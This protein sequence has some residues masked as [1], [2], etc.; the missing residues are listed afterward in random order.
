[1]KCRRWNKE[2]IKILRKRIKE[3]EL[4]IQIRENLR[5]HLLEEELLSELTKFCGESEAKH[6]CRMIRPYGVYSIEQVVGF[7]THNSDEDLV[8][9]LR[10]SYIGSKKVKLIREFVN[11][12][13]NL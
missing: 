2:G 6:L 11:H 10:G 12:Y 1:M 9:A 8:K 4:E 5:I 13:L 3:R 7:W